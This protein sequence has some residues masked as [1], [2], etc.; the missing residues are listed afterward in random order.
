MKRD[1]KKNELQ[2]LPG[3]KPALDLLKED[4]ARIAKIFC[5]LDKCG[6][7]IEALRKLCKQHSVPCEI[8]ETAKLDRLLQAAPQ[9]SHQ[10][11]IALLAPVPPRPLAELLRQA[12]KAPLP[13]L[14]ALDQIQ[15]PGNL[16]TLCRTAWALG[17]AGLI[18]PRHN[19][20]L[21][22]PAA[23][24]ASA[25]AIAQLPICIVTN[26]ARALDQAEEAGFAIYGADGSANKPLN[27]FQFAWQLPAVLTL[28]SEEHGIRPGVAKR[29]QTMLAIP[30]RRSFNSL[31]VAQAGAILMALCARQQ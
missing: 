23:A 27:A 10:G 17:C 24:K 5:R 16:G 22:S 14:L 12:P 4:P 28:G 11:V 30:F 18:L 3:L 13:L 6:A 15:D 20:A 21:P 8:V 7:D 31:N 9:T 25:G 1:A 2:I 29:C 19:S 26:L